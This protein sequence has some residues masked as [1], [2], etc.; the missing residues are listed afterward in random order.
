M[1]LILSFAFLFATGP[2]L[3]S[4]VEDSLTT[5]N[6][7]VKT[8]SEQEK[9]T[10]DETKTAAEEKAQEK[11]ARIEEYKKK[12]VEK[13]AETQAKRLATRCKSAQ[14]KITSL[15]ARIKNANENRR[16]VYQTM[17]EKL[18]TLV[19]RLVKAGIDT[20]KLETAREDIKADLEVLEA[21]MDSYETV[22]SDLEEMSCEEDPEAF[23]AA[24]EQA[25]LSLKS[26][27][28]QAQEFRRFSTSELKTILQDLKAQL[29]AETTKTT[30]GQN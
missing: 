28:E 13:L 24:L 7:A 20:T 25:R 10:T 4:A 30:G 18:D 26:L 14:G 19:E 5:T 3:A 11:A 23:Q 15:S 12:K 2:L 16:K 9:T 6:E 22:L 17:S 29:E 27:R 1:T 21:S 8:E